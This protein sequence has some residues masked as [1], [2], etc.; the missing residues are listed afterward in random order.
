MWKSFLS[1]T[2]LLQAFVALGSIFNYEVQDSNGNSVALSKYEDAKAILL[3]NSA[4]N[5]GYTYTNYRQLRDIYERLHPKGLEILAFPCNQ[6]GNQEPGTDE[7]I[8]T[9]ITNYGVTFPVF[10]KV[11]VNG[12][13]AHPLFKYLKEDSDQTELGWNF[14]KFLI[15]DGVPV[16][17]YPSKV[18]PKD[19]ESDILY[20]LEDEGEEYEDEYEL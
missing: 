18:K 3:L 5:C 6:F 15:V 10:A 4:S 17:R 9:F 2:F 7:E 19:I 11:D 16:K 14:V 8:Q 12:P 13:T 1:V 20:Y